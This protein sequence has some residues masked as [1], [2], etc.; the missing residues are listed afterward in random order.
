MLLVCEDHLDLAMDII[1][2]DYEKAP[3]LL[4]LEQAGLAHEQPPQKCAH[5]EALAQYVV[6]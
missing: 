3:E 6:S 1:V 5:C 2:D 4:T